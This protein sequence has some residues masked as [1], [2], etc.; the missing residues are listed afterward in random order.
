MY[1]IENDAVENAKISAEKA[2]AEVQIAKDERERKIAIGRY[3]EA[4]R[5]YRTMLSHRY[6]L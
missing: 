4:S 2:L 5:A 1:T 3:L 6:N